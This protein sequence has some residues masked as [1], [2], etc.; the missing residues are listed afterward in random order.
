MRTT[1]SPMLTPSFRT[2]MA[3]KGVAAAVEKLSEEER[4]ELITL[5]DL[6]NQR[7]EEQQQPRVVVAAA[8]VVYCARARIIRS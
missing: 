8:A 2:A 1:R 7:A 4:A 5:A 6:A 3:A